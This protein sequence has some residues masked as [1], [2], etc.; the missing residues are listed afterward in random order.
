MTAREQLC[1][2]ED[3]RMP[4]HLHARP[5]S[6][7]GFRGSSVG[8]AVSNCLELIMYGRPGAQRSIKNA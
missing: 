4:I 2:E 8:M 1:Y 5:T 6:A 3:A 7:S